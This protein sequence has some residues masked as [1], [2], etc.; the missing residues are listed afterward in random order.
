MSLSPEDR[1]LIE[2][3]RAG[4]EPAPADRN[5]LRGAIAA[6][7]GVAATISAASAGATSTTAGATLV[8]SGAGALV[9]VLGVLG[10][11]VVVGSVSYV[12]L[13]PRAEA[14][15]APVAQG[16]PQPPSAPAAEEP[17]VASAVPAPVEAP[18]ASAPSP[19]KAPSA[20]PATEPAEGALTHETRLVS[21]ARAALRAGNAS[22]ALQRLEEHARTFPA[23]VLAEERDAERVAA[24]CALGRTSE[25]RAR[26]TRFSREHPTS[27]L[28]AKVRATC[29]P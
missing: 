17:A 9:K 7:I 27:A 26:A 14:P 18:A 2:Q 22:G 28:G 29:A 24:L 15:A 1:A 11:L 21:E 16:A 10:A 19:R 4:L 13:A 8:T 5:R 23:G 25:A 12:A 6:Q 20:R 3:G